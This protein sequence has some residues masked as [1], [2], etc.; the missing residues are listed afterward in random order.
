MDQT[1]IIPSTV[2]QRW[3]PNQPHKTAATAVFHKAHEC[4]LLIALDIV[5]TPRG[6]ERYRKKIAAH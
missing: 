3:E 2:I 5:G 1:V 6:M 4:S